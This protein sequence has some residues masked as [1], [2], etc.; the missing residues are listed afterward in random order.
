MQSLFEFFHGLFISSLIQLAIFAVYFYAD[1]HLK[2]VEYDGKIF[3]LCPAFLG[4]KVPCFTLYSRMDPHMKWFF[5]I[6]FIFFGLAKLAHSLWMLSKQSSLFFNET[7]NIEYSQ[8]Q[9]TK[10]FFNC[11]DFNINNYSDSRGLRTGTFNMIYT[12]IF[13]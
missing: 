11:W 2:L 8:Q 9:I 5:P 1:I 3:D 10:M 7:I 4:T 12:E 6:S 13:E